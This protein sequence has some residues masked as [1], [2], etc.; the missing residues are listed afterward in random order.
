MSGLVKSFLFRFL[1]IMWGV[2]FGLF[3]GLIVI[4]TVLRVALDY[5]FHWGDSGPEWV[6]WLILLLTLLSVF[7]S[8]FVFLRWTNSHLR[9]DK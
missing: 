7:V 2:L 8:C 9:Q 1:T 6:N 4:S 3:A 5:A